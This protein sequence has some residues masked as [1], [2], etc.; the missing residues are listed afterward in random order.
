MKY[1]S[2]SLLAVLLPAIV[3]AAIP[4]NESEL[5]ANLRVAPPAALPLLNP[6][7]ADHINYLFEIRQTCDFVARYQFSD[8][9]K[10][11]S[12][13]GII[14]AEHLP[15]TIETDNTQEA[16]WVWTRWYELTGRD[17][18]RT[19]IHRA[20]FYVLRHPAYREGTGQYVWYSVWNCGL[21]FFAEMKYRAVYG[22]SS[23]LAYADTCR[24]FCY[25][26]P[27]NFA[28]NTL[29]GNVTALAAGMMYRYA[30]ERGS[31]ALRDT[32]LAYGNR[33]KDWVEQQPSRLRTGNWA[34]S[35]GT[36]LWGLCNSIW[37]EDTVA[38]KTWLAVFADSVPYFM[39]SGQWNCSWNIWDANAF[40]A[41]AEIGHDPRYL[42]YHQR[43][44]D[45]L[46][47]RDQDDD[48]GIPATWT[49]PQNQDQAWVSMYLD[50]MGMDRFLEPIYDRD[51]G[52][53]GIA[54]LAPDRVYLPGDSL[55]VSCSV[56]NFGRDSLGS[57]PVIVR[58]PSAEDT[59]SLNLG[60]LQLDTIGIGPVILSVPG[61]IPLIGFTNL[62]GDQNRGNDTAYASVK[63][64]TPRQITGNLLD[65]LT[66]QPFAGQVAFFL[67][68]D[69]TPFRVATS[70]SLGHFTLTGID[71]SFRVIVH[72]ELPY[73][74]REWNVRVLSDT[75]LTCAIPPAHLLLVDNDSLSHWES[76]YV[77]TFDTLGLSYC[78]WRRQ[79]RG[80]I[81]ISKL[82]EFQENLL[83]WYTGLT[84]RA[85]LDASDMDSLSRFLDS[86]GR[87]FITG[88]D[89]GQELALTQFYQDRLHA[90]LVD[91]TALLYYAFGNHADSLG[92]LFGQT[93]T[94][95]TQGANDQTSRDVIAPDSLAHAFLY[96]DTMTRQTAGICCHDAQTQSRVI[97]LG[98]GFEAM[99]RPTGHPTYDSRVTFFQKCHAWL[100]GAGG[101]AEFNP[102]RTLGLGLAAEPNPF[103]SRALISYTLASPTDVRLRVYSSTGALVAVLAQGRQPTG[104]HRFAWNGCEGSGHAV[105]PGVYVLRLETGGRAF[106]QKLVKLH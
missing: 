38:G 19:N 84:R 59:I 61:V 41:A 60:F 93:Q 62:V 103:P 101:I 26:N 65:S 25:A 20:W 69:T 74:D 15:T 46:L 10:P 58:L 42:Q 94:A 72:P 57:V 6:Q 102:A 81:P 66:S 31:Q 51:A 16:I 9:A 54:P 34:M 1:W 33:V 50:F 98:F 30:L 106:C 83:I 79:I 35:G 70:D 76:Y 99:N 13:G 97:Y 71:S 40:R 2:R 43:L 55:T 73:P 27:L 86:G 85:T 89:I 52:V 36:L 90:R 24:Q 4:W 75:T 91:T 78:T 44:V 12:F 37:L 3:L 63:V 29:H 45:T 105:A 80:P 17:D 5:R 32:A 21:G 100:I 47:S 67:G 49:D 23:Y 77:S 7:L 53:V 11:D 64:W 88:Q 82:P 14:E 104:K 48:G 18:Y 8:S 22:D 92:A 95:G 68:N 28:A 39:P 87:L 96:Y 56:A